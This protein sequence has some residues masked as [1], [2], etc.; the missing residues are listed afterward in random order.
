M[1]LTGFDIGP[2]TFNGNIYTHVDVAPGATKHYLEDSERFFRYW[3]EQ[4]NGAVMDPTE[5]GKRGGEWERTK[6]SKS[7]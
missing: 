2:I 6:R 3:V 7:F 5:W 4:I 1:I